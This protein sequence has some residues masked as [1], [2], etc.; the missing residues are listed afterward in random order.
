MNCSKRD[1]VYSMNIHTLLT[2]SLAL[3]RGFLTSLQPSLF[4]LC[5]GGMLRAASPSIGEAPVILIRFMFQYINLSCEM[6][7]SLIGR[8]E[9]SSESHPLKNVSKLPTIRRAA[10]RSRSRT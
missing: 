3:L 4:S 6:F 2:S 9:D 1:H 5:G 7:L 8:T 10:Q